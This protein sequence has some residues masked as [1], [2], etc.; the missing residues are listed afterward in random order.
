LALLAA[1]AQVAGCGVWSKPDTPP[2][3]LAP[4]G[5][6]AD[7]PSASGKTLNDLAS[8]ADGQGPLLAPSVPIVHKGNNRYGFGLFDTAREQ[9][10]GAEVAVY[11]AREDGTG[12]RGPH[13]ARSESLAVRPQF[14]SETSAKNPSAA[15]S[16]YVA[17]VPF[18][19]RGKQL[20]VTASGRGGQE[21][22]A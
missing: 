11:T 9:I 12:V 13:V 21:L 10:T 22:A 5:Q 6:P 18:K 17:D 1:A 3:Q 2:S 19:R 7:L 20:L 4:T 14:Q 15:K 16:V 8:M